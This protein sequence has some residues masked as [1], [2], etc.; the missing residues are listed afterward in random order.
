MLDE[1]LPATRS[2]GVRCSKGR[3]HRGG[4]L[5]VCALLTQPASAG[6]REEQSAPVVPPAI[7]H[8]HSAHRLIELG[9]PDFAL[10]HLL[11]ID[12]EVLPESGLSPYTA[13][14][15]YLA[16]R[17]DVLGEALETL[18]ASN[19]TAE[20]LRPFAATWNARAVVAIRDGRV[21]EALEAW[22]Q[23]LEREPSFGER[24]TI[25]RSAIARI[26]NTDAGYIEVDPE[27]QGGAL[28]SFLETWG[29]RTSLGLD[30][31]VVELLFALEK[32]LD[33]EGPDAQLWAERYLTLT[34]ATPLALYRRGALEM[35]RRQ[36]DM[37]LPW[38]LWAAHT[39]KFASDLSPKSWR[40]LAVVYRE[41]GWCDRA[42]E[43]WELALA[44][45]RPPCQP[46][47]RRSTNFEECVDWHDQ[48]LAYSPERMIVFWRGSWQDSVPDLHIW[49]S[50]CRWPE[51]SPFAHMSDSYDCSRNRRPRL[52]ERQLDRQGPGSFPT[53]LL[54]AL[55]Q[56][57]LMFPALGRRFDDELLT[58]RLSEVPA[59]QRSSLWEARALFSLRQGDVDQAM[60]YF[61]NVL[62]HD[63]FARRK[64]D[65]WRR[66][67]RGL[68]RSPVA[69][70]DRVARFLRDTFDHHVSTEER[71]GLYR[72]HLATHLRR[73]AP[74]S[75]IT[76][77][78]VDEILSS[79]LPHDGSL[80]MFRTT[81]ELDLDRP[82]DALP[83][84]LQ[85]YEELGTRELP[86]LQPDRGRYREIA[87]T[88][89]SVYSRLRWWD[90]ALDIAATLD[91][92]I[93]EL[94]AL[95]PADILESSLPEQ[96]RALRSR[97]EKGR[98]ASLI[99][100]EGEWHRE[101]LRILAEWEGACT[102]LRPAE[103]E[104]SPAS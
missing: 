63:P 103:R 99:R 71:P 26:G 33:P 59:D 56:A 41:L 83:H 17:L 21:S 38:F 40:S 44:Q 45:G 12:H 10:E 97:L 16:A 60:A 20:R 8:L 64:R 82:A 25:F 55:N 81:I 47:A 57:K 90:L 19:L 94:S 28:R 66:F 84:L 7:Q 31:E 58:R 22:D 61:W 79:P 51:P 95:D 78:L 70:G 76:L 100:T 37:A 87:G 102:S 46:A 18:T 67:S 50:R 29:K 53:R 91:S 1:V 42:A 6:A 43:A 104:S 77:R 85:A 34:Q 35:A 23:S 75:S 73:V 4:L 86:A 39:D 15:A 2:G 93:P 68:S 88:L 65:R 30:P 80:S 96:C 3:S 49:R 24:R 92:E 32:K 101:R 52:A 89:V 11:E 13:Q 72:V 48:L 54:C 62:E 74:S 14:I 9:L 36:P 98:G 27:V 5:L 69:R